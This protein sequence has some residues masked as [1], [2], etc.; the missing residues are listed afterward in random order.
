MYFVR[1][2]R[3]ATAACVAGMLSAHGSIDHVPVDS[4]M[5][6]ETPTVAKAQLSAS[7]QSKHSS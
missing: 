2:V 5:D 3:C 7:S 6:A 1:H 4:S